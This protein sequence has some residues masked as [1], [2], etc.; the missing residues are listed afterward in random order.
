MGLRLFERG[1]S[2]TKPTYDGEHILTKARRLLYQAH[3][4]SREAALLKS[5]HLGRISIGVGSAIPSL[6]LD[7]LLTFTTQQHP[8]LSVSV[9]L[10]SARVLL[11]HLSEERIE[12]FVGDAHYLRP[13][14]KIF[15]VQVL[16]EMTSG[17]YVRA[18]HPLAKKRKLAW[19]DLQPYPQI[20]AYVRDSYQAFHSDAEDRIVPELEPKVLCNDLSTLH[21][22]MLNT[23]AVLL[24][25]SPMLAD[26]LEQGLA[27]ELKLPQQENPVEVKIAIVS[28][29]GRSPSSAGKLLREKI[30]S[31]FAQN[32]VNR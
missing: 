23:N 29:V 6:F 2:G 8:S 4:L 28:L 16:E 24:G 26:L 31:I 10:D 22:V 7:Q 1:K 11:R 15:E 14:P 13:D 19:S 30:L 9:E 5:S 3:V 17:C 20:T 27:R 21:K 18:E 25:V 12:F 32:S